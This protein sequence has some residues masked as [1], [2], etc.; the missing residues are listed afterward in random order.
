M[1]SWKGKTNAMIFPD[2][3]GYYFF[4]LSP[5][6]TNAYFLKSYLWCQTWNPINGLSHSHVKIRWLITQC[7]GSLIWLILQHHPLVIWKILVHWVMHVF[8]MLTQFHYRTFLVFILFIL[9]IFYCFSS[10]VVSIFLPLLLPAPPPPPTINLTSF[11]FVHGSFIQV[12]WQT[13]PFLFPVI[14]FPTPLWLL[15]VCSFFQCL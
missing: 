5:N 4:K 14:P 8:K 15:S 11:G 9:L 6:L 13:F 7:D 2:N 10:T 1:W 3:Y 12:P